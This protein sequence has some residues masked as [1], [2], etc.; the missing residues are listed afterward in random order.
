MKFLA[1]DDCQGS[2]LLSNFSCLNYL[3]FDLTEQSEFV[4]VILI[5]SRSVSY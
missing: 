2:D 3:D 1:I 5:Q 4:T